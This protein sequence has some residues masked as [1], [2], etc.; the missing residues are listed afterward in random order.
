MSPA[1][2][3]R[4]RPAISLKSSSDSFPIARSNS[5]SLIARSASIFS[6]SSAARV[7]RPMTTVRSSSADTSGRTMRST[8]RPTRTTA[9][10]RTLR[11]M[12]LAAPRPRA[13]NVTAVAQPSAA[14]TKNCHGRSTAGSELAGGLGSGFRAAGALAGAVSRTSIEV[15][16]L[17]IQSLLERGIAV[18]H[19]SG[20]GRRR[21]LPRQPDGDEADADR[22]AHADEIREQPGETVEALVERRAE[23]VLPAV[24]LDERGDDLIA[25][26]P[27]VHHVVQD[28]L[29]RLAHVAVEHRAVVQRALAAAAHAE[30][31]TL[32]LLLERLEIDDRN[33]FS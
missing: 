33:L 22:A 19:V 5:S 6:R 32:H 15:S 11:R 21:V 12:T 2:R 17:I 3:T 29:L 13:M 25:R 28:L 14:S 18:A 1:A 26:L 31:L 20:I 30:D 24:A 4:R 9:P 10:I 23:H 27:L 7:R 8:A 16:E